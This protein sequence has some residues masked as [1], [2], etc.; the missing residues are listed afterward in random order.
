MQ[1][2]TWTDEQL[3]RAWQ[4]RAPGAEAEAFRRFAPQLLRYAA[5]RSGVP[6]DAPDIVQDTFLRASQR[7]GQLRH[8]VHL[9]A[10]LYAIARNLANDAHRRRELSHQ[11]D[12][13]MLPAQLGDPVA[14]A[15][16]DAHQYDRV[17]QVL[18]LLRERDRQIIDLHTRFDA[19][20]T[21]VAA[22]L[23]VEPAHAYV[24]IGRAR[25]RFD[26]ILRAA[27]LLD[28]GTGGCRQL[29]AIRTVPSERGAHVRAA[30][31]HLTRCASCAQTVRDLRRR[32]ETLVPGRVAGRARGGRD[33][34]AT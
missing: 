11:I 22:A 5:R 19:A 29:A 27:D 12:D 15:T 21:G 14:T 17:H 24:L 34:A 31:R 10:W 16:I 7:V 2:G 18:G 3:A 13:T 8:P 33:D 23:G 28:A 32:D 30:R 1:H 20:G 4:H 6:D 25:A 26:E 9:R